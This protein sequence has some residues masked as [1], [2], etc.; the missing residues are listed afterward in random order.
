MHERIRDLYEKLILGMD[1][2]HSINDLLNILKKIGATR[3]EAWIVLYQG[4]GMDEKEAETVVWNSDIENET[5]IET[6]EQLAIYVFNA[7]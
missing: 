6:L 2:D 1:E 4:Y 7:K 5:Y 3:T